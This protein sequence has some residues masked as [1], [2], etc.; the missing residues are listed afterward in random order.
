[1]EWY[2]QVARC[3]TTPLPAPTDARTANVTFCRACALDDPAASVLAV[4]VAENFS[5]LRSLA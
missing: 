3:A 4:G 1:M 2:V 5:S